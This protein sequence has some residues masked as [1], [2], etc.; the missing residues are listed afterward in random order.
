MNSTRLALYLPVVVIYYLCE[1]TSLINFINTL[2][3]S[4]PSCKSGTYVAAYI[5]M[6]NDFS[7]YGSRKRNRTTETKAIHYLVHESGTE[8]KK[9]S[10]R[11]SS[12]FSSFPSTNAFLGILRC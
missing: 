12:A 4:P 6:H 8:E 11:F 1:N 9:I 2:T 3:V 5:I 10:L 7:V